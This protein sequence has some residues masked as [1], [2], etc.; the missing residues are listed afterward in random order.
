MT[1]AA[2]A[3]GACRPIVTGHHI[4][5]LFPS[6][7]PPERNR[8]VQARVARTPIQSRHPG[9]DA[10]KPDLFRNALTN[11]TH[12]SQDTDARKKMRE[13]LYDT[14]TTRQRNSTRQLRTAATLLSPFP[15]VA[16]MADPS[17]S[18]AIN[19]IKAYVFKAN[20]QISTKTD[21]DL[22]PANVP[23]C[24]PPIQAKDDR[25]AAIC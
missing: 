6:G 10:G 5:L 4:L 19:E 3:A 21:L 16:L 9:L 15:L 25:T 17:S 22:S 23:S 18:S 11:R 14:S 20:S 2:R 13:H 1:L 7:N 24:P 8:G 12:E